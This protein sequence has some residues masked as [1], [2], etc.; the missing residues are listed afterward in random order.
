MASI[1]MENGSGFDICGK[2]MLKGSAEVDPF[3]PRVCYNVVKKMLAIE[4]SQR[5]TRHNIGAYRVTS[6]GCGFRHH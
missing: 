1:H 2:S 6:F 5:F 4:L 3:N